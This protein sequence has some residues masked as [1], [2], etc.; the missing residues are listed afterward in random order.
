MLQKILFCK[1]IYAFNEFFNAES[2][3]GLVFF[4]SRTVAE[5]I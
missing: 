4:I 2:N 1:A 5:I 3:G